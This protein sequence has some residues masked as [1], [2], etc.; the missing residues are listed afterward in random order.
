MEQMRGLIIRHYSQT[1]YDKKKENKGGI[2]VCVYIYRH[3][4]LSYFMII[5]YMKIYT[6]THN[7]C[8]TIAMVVGWL[9]REIIYNKLNKRHNQK[10][11]PELNSET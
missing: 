5:I 6:N 8:C 3:F 10:I 9:V 7:A 11:E 2:F 4:Y 1:T